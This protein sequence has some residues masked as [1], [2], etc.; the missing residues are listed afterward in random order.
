M[1]ADDVGLQLRHLLRL[2]ALVHKK[3]EAGV[4]AVNRLAGCRE[5]FQIILRRQHLHLRLVADGDPPFCLG[6]K[7]PLRERIKLLK[8]Q[9]LAV[10]N[11]LLHAIPLP[12]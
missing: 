6:I 7:R 3:P 12:S 5:F 11:D 2:D 8:V 9:I 1:R 10:K 4:D